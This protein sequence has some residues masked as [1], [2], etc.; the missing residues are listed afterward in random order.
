MKSVDSVR[1]TFASAT[2]QSKLIPIRTLA[3][4]TSRSVFANTYAKIIILKLRAFVDICTGTIVS[5]QP[6]S[7]VATAPVAAPCVCTRVLAQTGGS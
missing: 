1:D 2:V 5:V 3:A 7:R 6:E 4:I